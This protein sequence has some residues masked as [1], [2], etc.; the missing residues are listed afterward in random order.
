MRR[1][2]TIVSGASKLQATPSTESPTPT[3]LPSPIPP[4]PPSIDRPTFFPIPSPLILTVLS[5]PKLAVQIT[6][7]I[8]GKAIQL[9]GDQGA[10]TSIICYNLASSLGLIQRIH[11]LNQPCSIQ[12]GLGHTKRASGLIDLRFELDGHDFRHQV[13]VV[14]DFSNLF[15]LGID[16]FEAHSWTKPNPTATYYVFDGDKRVNYSPH[17]L[18]FETDPSNVITDRK[19][20]IPV[21][22]TINIL[23]HLQP[24]NSQPIAVGTEGLMRPDHHGIRNIKG[25]EVPHMLAEVYEGTRVRVIMTNISK[26]P[27]SVPA[28]TKVAI[29]ATSTFIGIVNKDSKQGPYH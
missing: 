28:G 22:A 1:M 9:C 6:G 7:K 25:L 23:S 5:R 19:Y 13:L 17:H 11:P 24:Q 10:V 2:T 21:G 18:R 29:F 15:L 27:I 8:R 16:F 4:E 26:Q 14:P 3:P 12:T 20:K